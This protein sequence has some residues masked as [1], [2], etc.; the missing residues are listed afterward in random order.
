MKSFLQGMTDMTIFV[1]HDLYHEWLP[2]NHPS[3]AE[4]FV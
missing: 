4:L 2:S 3:V 1:T